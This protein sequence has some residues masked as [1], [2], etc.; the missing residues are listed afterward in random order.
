MI[1]NEK[2]IKHFKAGKPTK[3]REGEHVDL[4]VAIFGKGEGVMA[5]C[6][7][8]IITKST[9]YLWLKVH[10]EFKYAYD[11]VM[12]VAGRQWEAYP[13]K[14]R[15]F[16]FPYWSTIMR[17]RFGFGK[18]MV[19]IAKDVTPLARVEAIWQSIEH[20]ELSGQE[21]TQFI[22]VV[23]AQADILN[24]S[25]QEA[26][27]FKLDSDE[28]LMSKIE[29]LEDSIEFKKWKKDVKGKK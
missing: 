19:R 23:K 15:S 8:A 25:S 12:N 16:N 9:F 22:S 5:F 7:E 21:S 26:E 27:E 13:L 6:A 4:L 24:S 2:L 14:D 20:G 18:P 28:E 17:N 3:Y 29:R 10:A 11:V 1:T